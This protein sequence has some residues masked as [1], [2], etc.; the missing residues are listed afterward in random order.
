MVYSLVNQKISILKII[1]YGLYSSQVLNWVLKLYKNKSKNVPWTR[2]TPLQRWHM[3]LR[4][5]CHSGNGMHHSG[6]P[7]TAY[8]TP[9][10]AYATPGTAH[11][12]LATAHATL[13]MAYS[14][15]HFDNGTCHFGKGTCHFVNGT[16]HFGNGIRHLPL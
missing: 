3:P 15:C 1:K 5:T 16:C 8:A 12:T 13:A 9:G 2:Y 11:A 10:T 7:A 6:T 4:H 14:T